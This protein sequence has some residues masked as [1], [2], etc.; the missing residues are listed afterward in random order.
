MAKAK[1]MFRC[2]NCGYEFPQWSGRCSE[3][4]NWNSMEQLQPSATTGDAATATAP[5]PLPQIGDNDYGRRLSTGFKELDRVLGGGLV[6]DTA[7]LLGGDPGIGKSTLLLQWLDSMQQQGVEVLY[8]SGEE[9]ANQIA[10][11]ARRLGLKS[12]L[13]VLADNN[14]QNTIQIALDTAPGILAIDS[15]QTLYSAELSSAPGTVSQL[16]ECTSRCVRLAKERGMAVILVGHVTK[17]G[18]LAGPRVLEH[19]VDTV[20]YFEGNTGSR[21]RMLRT[22]K[23]RYGE[24]NEL[25]V[26]AMTD[27]GLREVGNPSAIFISGRASDTPGSLVMVTR[28]GNRPILTEIQALCDD[29]RGSHPR[30]L[31]VGLAQNRLDLLL[32]VLHRHGNMA[33][34]HLDVFV[35]VAGGIKISETAADLPMLLAIASS[36]KNQPLPTDLVAFG[37]IGLAGE[38]R[39]VPGG[40]ERIAEAKRQGFKRAIIAKGNS[41]KPAPAGMKLN[42]VS[43][44]EE[45]LLAAELSP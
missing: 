4:N 28:E 42:V 5:V 30:R 3:C 23:N 43:R 44:L 8:A 27:S 13:P 17:E 40:P 10:E 14:L 32:A 18:V 34:G 36:L 6:P 16:R 11:R 12:N 24:V 25:G 33:A 1:T 21:H 7:V 37:E 45:A 19:M 39:P 2:N 26:F 9:S 29:T 22:V 15:V 35:N 20:M 31:V 41:P 38:I